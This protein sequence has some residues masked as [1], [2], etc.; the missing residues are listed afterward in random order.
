MSDVIDMDNLARERISS[1]IGTNFFVE[2]GAGSGKTTQLVERMTAMIKSGIDVSKISAITFTK[3]AAREFY[4][5]FQKSLINQIK[6]SDDEIIRLRCEIAL[7]NIDLSFMGTIDAFS[8]LILHEHPVEGHIPS[9]AEV[10]AAEE[11]KAIYKREYSFI[12]RGYYG[13]DLLKKFNTFSCFQ[14]KP[15]RTFVEFLPTII[16]SRNAD[17]IYDNPENTDVD[18]LFSTEKHRLMQALD[19]L[20]GRKDLWGTTKDCDKQ[21]KL[22]EQKYPTLKKKWNE[23]AGE[24]IY[25]LDK[26][27]GFRFYGD[28]QEIGIL[29]ISLFEPY[30]SRN[31]IQYYK[32]S[33]KESDL[34]RQLREL[35]YS[36]TIDFLVSASDA[37]ADRL[38]QSGEL[39]YFDYKLYL[40]DMLKRDSAVEGKLIRHIYD[41][42][43][44]YL[45]D[46]FQDTDPM[47]AEIFFYLTAENPVENWRK[48]IPRP[49]SL[50]I[51]GDP[52]QSIYRFRAADVTAFKDVRQ[53]FENGVGDVLQLTRNYRSAVKLK[54]WFNTVFSILLG[55][56]DPLQSKFSPIPIEGKNDDSLFSGIWTYNVNINRQSIVDDEQKVLQIIRCL[57]DNPLYLIKD[58]H[59]GTRR[60][61]KYSDF[62][63]IVYNKDHILKFMREFDK[64][65]IPVKAEGKILLSDC[66]ALR[67]MAALM[68]AITAPN[69][70]KAVYGA[71]TSSIFGITD[72]EIIAL[73][74]K[75]LYTELY[76]TK[77]EIL[78]ENPRIEAAFEKLKK[79][80][81][82]AENMTA[83]S[84]FTTIM[85]DL[86]VLNRTGTDYLE[87]LYYA[88]ELLRSAEESGEIMSVSDGA[89]FLRNLLDESKEERCISLPKDENRVHIANLHKVK[90][91]EAPVVILADPKC[92]DFVPTMRIEH[93]D[94]SSTCHIFSLKKNKENVAV[95]EKFKSELKAEEIAQSAEKIRLLYVA[96]T[97]AQ[98]ALIIA[99]GVNSSGERASN[100]PW[101][102][103]VLKA[104]GDI[105]KTLHIGN[106][107]ESSDKEQVSAEELYNAACAENIFEKSYS[108]KITYLV[109]SP[110]RIKLK[111]IT[112]GADDFED[113]VDTEIRKNEIRTDAAFT[114]TLIHKLMEYLVTAKIA[115]DAD[116]LADDIIGKFNAPKEYKKILIDVYKKIVNGGYTQENGMTEDILHEIRNSEEVYCEM[117]FCHKYIEENG[118]FTLWHGVIDLIYKKDGK[119]HIVDY[120]T[121]AE[122]DGLDYKYSEQLEAY[123]FAFHAMTGE[124]ADAYIYHIDV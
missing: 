98:N 30:I 2:A 58:P 17:F 10:R 49:G 8:H 79:L 84:M 15:E 87:Y 95:T 91:L 37:I 3:A 97:R 39:T 13:N 111:S 73:A 67:A 115:P 66:P 42:H 118:M 18:T 116:E 19:R 1:D 106:T 33:I 29:D 85:D 90:G 99:N 11:L 76:T 81:Y 21:N 119:W 54:E 93:N 70:R 61:L 26:L 27:D 89:K 9:D 35:Q 48:C 16:N 104:S 57:V 36:V 94:A 20:M 32:L 110:S 53:L 105:F 109:A 75:G 69:D 14:E 101:E 108:Y 63:V 92:S 100:N 22:F 43:R 4:K 31:K 62:M 5:R 68:E 50:F 120:K 47:Q 113:N 77:V 38:R 112:S 56:D 103:F 82:V 121:N 78:S 51:V 7:Q 28:P 86:K 34:Y 107:V 124:S 6:K 114:G 55:R 46:E 60:M 102:A 12:L 117:P 123:K 80:A 96:A 52:K 44:Y 88:L 45:I 74:D 59:N 41:R 83:V 72:N 40:R 122:A 24:I 25:V 65:D 71:L 64:A 23:N